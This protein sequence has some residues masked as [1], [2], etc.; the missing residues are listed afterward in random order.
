M[1]NPLYV[2][3]LKPGMHRIGKGTERKIKLK[4]LVSTQGTVSE[5]KIK[6]LARFTKNMPGTVTV[7]HRGHGKYSILDGNHRANAALK[8]GKQKITVKVQRMQSAAAP[9]ELASAAWQRKEGKSESGGLNRKGVASYR[10]ENPG[11]KLKTAVTTPPSKLDP[12]SKPAKRRKSFCA[13]MSGMQGPMEKPNGEPTRK[14][15]SLRKWNCSSKAPLI[16]FMYCTA[17]PDGDT[18]GKRSPIAGPKRRTIAKRKKIAAK[19][20]QFAEELQP[21]QRRVIRRIQD[22]SQSGLVVAHG[23]GSGK[24]RTAIEAHKAMGGSADVILPAALRENYRKETARWGGP[25]ANVM[26]QQA[27]SLKGRGALKSRLLIV[28]EAHRARN[29]KSALS[30]AIKGSPAQKRML[31]TG[32]PIF[33]NPSDIGTLVN[34]AAGKPVLREGKAFE[35]RYTRPNF[36]SRWRG[37]RLSHSGELKKVLNKYVDY[38]KGD[39][40]MLPKVTSQTIPVE[41]TK[42]QSALYRASLG[43][44]PKG[45][46]ISQEN[47]DRLKP[48]LTGPRQVS[49]S[50]RALDPS[51]ADEP[52]IDRAFRDLEGH[53]KNPKGKALVYSNWLK[54][55]IEPL[56]QRLT[57]AKIPHGVFTGNETMKVRNQ[58]VRDY[59]EGRHRAL[60]VSSSG[61]EGLDLKGTRMVQVLE[62]HFNNAKIRQVVGRSARMGSHA[63]L[64]PED[65]SVDV[66]SY[67]GRPK[68]R[69]FPGSSKGVEDLLNDSARDKDEVARQIT[70]LLSSKMKTIRFDRPSEAR[71][72][73]SQKR[74]SALLRG[75][76]WEKNADLR[77]IRQAVQSKADPVFAS[78]KGGEKKITPRVTD[79][80]GRQRI[81]DPSVSGAPERRRG[82]ESTQL[83]PGMEKYPKGEFKKGE[84]YAAAPRAKKHQ[85]LPHLD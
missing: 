3:G 59:N 54:H 52:K 26:S 51:S 14:A 50:A 47:I 17:E 38:H 78:F 76:V 1:K 31:L 72:A 11:S 63:S 2:E 65:R 61:A 58:T 60:L 20:I 29:P 73:A 74:A 77:A 71:T 79:V 39:P 41:M 85:E 9:I 62:P 83:L 66:R 33:N 21:H 25:E 16:Q 24:T 40:S 67:V 5:K 42:H 82:A 84:D 6:K 15:L 19:P 36:F 8:Q 18:G 34:Q 30:D 44:V 12:D 64:D 37:E 75:S 80:G 7:S 68:N 32:T 56:Q 45:L 23:L 49:N 4:N 46:K 70:R 55:G 57:A 27:L 28:D 35:N 10:R 53:L 81:L 48:Y 43:G 69:F 13:R 22:P